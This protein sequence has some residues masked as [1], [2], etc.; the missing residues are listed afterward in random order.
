M[1]SEDVVE[2]AETWG[3]SPFPAPEKAK[4]WNPGELEYS[5]PCSSKTCQSTFSC[6]RS[7]GVSRV[8]EE[9]ERPQTS[10]GVGGELTYLLAKVVG[11]KAELCGS[12]SVITQL[13]S[14]VGIAQGHTVSR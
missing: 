7:E 8:T 13:S 6:F 9:H 14:L 5:T 11:L 10:A 3:L 2:H 4:A 12:N 1:P